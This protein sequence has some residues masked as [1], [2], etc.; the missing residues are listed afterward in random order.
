MLEVT[1]NIATVLTSVIALVWFL[2]TR[3][4]NF[5]ENGNVTGLYKA[6]KSLCRREETNDLAIIEFNVDFISN[7]GWFTGRI[8][9]A[10]IF[11][12][13]GARSEGG[14]NCIGYVKY[15]VLNDLMSALIPSKRN[16][17]EFDH[18]RG[19][20]GKLF[21]ISRNDFGVERNWK[22]FL[23]ESYDLIFYRNTFRIE[24]FNKRT[25]SQIIT[26]LKDPLVFVNTVYVKDNMYQLTTKTEFSLSHKT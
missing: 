12:P 4:R 22:E 9:Y 11:K 3:K 8:D 14:F 6:F 18:A 16:P 15:N 20:K 1:S 23:M 17:L 7:T 13:L 2:Y 19:Y 26:Q 21:I 5:F 25:H 10:E 24:I